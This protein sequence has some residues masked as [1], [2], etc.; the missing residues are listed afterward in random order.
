MC[1]CNQA[2]QFYTIRHTGHAGPAPVRLHLKRICYNAVAAP[3]DGL[4]ILEKLKPLALLWLRLVLGLVFFYHG[5]QTLFGAPTAALQAFR[6]MGLPA[7]FVYL[8]GTLELFGAI[9]LAFGLL[10][11]VTALLL[12]IE[13]AVVLVKTV[14]PRMGLSGVPNYELILTLCGATFA[15]AA[16][17]AGLISIDA[18]TFERPGSSRIKLKK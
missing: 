8:S 12:G 11:R 15:L 5:Y 9:L 7:Y 4:Q 14:Q 10:T 1:K 17:G 6:H 2:N 18:A 16:V 3:E 13:M